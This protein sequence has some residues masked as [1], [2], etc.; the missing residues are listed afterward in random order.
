MVC[1]TDLSFRSW[2]LPE[3]NAKGS[4]TLLSVFRARDHCKYSIE[5]VSI[6]VSILL[7]LNVWLPSI[8]SDRHTFISCND[9][10]CSLNG[11][12]GSLGALL[13]GMHAK[14][15][16]YSLH[17]PPRATMATSNSSYAG[18]P[19]TLAPSK[20]RIFPLQCLVSL[21]LTHYN[22]PHGASEMT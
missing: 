2:I 10:P 16:R 11:G 19:S 21:R 4:D 13:K 5:V 22:T 18:T 6:Y 17:A 3:P 9:L 14:I 8:H 20:I 12:L 15:V 1:L 7:A